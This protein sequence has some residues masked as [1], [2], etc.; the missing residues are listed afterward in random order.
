MKGSLCWYMFDHKDFIL[1]EDIQN[2][3]L[4]ICHI[5]D[6]YSRTC[7]ICND[8]FFNIQHTYYCL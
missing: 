8:A 4:G 6:R 7:G 2:V 1:S 5:E 3:L